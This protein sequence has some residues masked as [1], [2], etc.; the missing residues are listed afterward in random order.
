MG[1][2][3]LGCFSEE[4]F[5]VLRT[6]SSRRAVGVGAS[7]ADGG[8]VSGA[9]EL[10]SCAVGLLS[11]CKLLSCEDR[12]LSCDMGK[13]QGCGRLTALSTGSVGDWLSV[14]MSCCGL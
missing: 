7:V 10:S 4:E 1:E 14:R 2:G 8:T 9:R 3:E 11:C 5:V 6:V 13:L 12:R